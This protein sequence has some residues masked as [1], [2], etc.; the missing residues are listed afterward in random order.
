MATLHPLLPLK[1]SNN[2]MLYV[3][4][5]E[6]PS[7]FPVN[8]HCSTLFRV[9]DNLVEPGHSPLKA[10]KSI[11]EESPETKQNAKTRRTTIGKL[12]CLDSLS[13]VCRS[14]PSLVHNSRKPVLRKCRSLPV[15][16]TVSFCS[17]DRVRE[18][19]MVK[20]LSPGGAADV[21]W[22]ASEYKQTRQDFEG[23]L[24]LLESDIFIDER[25]HSARG[26]RHRTEEGV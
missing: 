2:G 16:K 19:E 8:Q 26:L 1:K 15:N 25:E 22:S 3:Q 13:G 10:P 18:I 24:Y 21:W 11:V 17:N 14:E 23:I 4:I 9:P 6:C 12:S 5:G 7:Y 20:A